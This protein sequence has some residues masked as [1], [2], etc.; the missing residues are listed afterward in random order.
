MGIQKVS[1]TFSMHQ[2]VVVRTFMQCILFSNAHSCLN[3]IGN[4]IHGVG[5][6]LGG[7]AFRRNIDAALPPQF[8]FAKSKKVMLMPASSHA[9]YSQ[10]SIRTVADCDMQELESAA[11]AT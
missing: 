3:M 9:A 2:V 4:P 6:V 8:W 5:V 7:H 1:D 10:Y 11:A